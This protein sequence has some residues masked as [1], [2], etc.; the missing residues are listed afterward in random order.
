MPY[1]D[2]LKDHEEAQSSYKL[3]EMLMKQLTDS[4][5]L[6]LKVQQ[7]KEYW[8]QEYDLLQLKCSNVSIKNI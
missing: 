2:A 5:E 3:R 4:Q 1:L 7:E 6:L 8:K